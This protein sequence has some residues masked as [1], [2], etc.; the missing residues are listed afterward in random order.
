MRNFS[1]VLK[2]IVFSHSCTMC[3]GSLLNVLTED[4]FESK[5]EFD[6]CQDF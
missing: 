6:T 2:V 4:H 5:H 3:G 1:R